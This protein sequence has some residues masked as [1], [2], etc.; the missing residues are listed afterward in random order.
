[1]DKGS[2][3]VQTEAQ[4]PQ[5]KQNNENGPKHVNPPCSHVAVAIISDSANL[6]ISDTSKSGQE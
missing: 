3:D 5:N 2:A 6:L 4:K 1:M